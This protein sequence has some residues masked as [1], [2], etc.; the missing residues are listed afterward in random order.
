MSMVPGSCAGLVPEMFYS[1]RVPS[2]LCVVA[3][4]FTDRLPFMLSVDGHR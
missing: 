1:L 2:G 3:S 4:S